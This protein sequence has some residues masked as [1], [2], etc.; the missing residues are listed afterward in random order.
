MFPFNRTIVELKA[1]FFILKIS[2]Q[3]SFNRTIVELKEKKARKGN[4]EIRAFNRTIVELKVVHK[5]GYIRFCG[6]LIVP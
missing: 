3:R 1:L 5:N 4:K 2:A 6:L